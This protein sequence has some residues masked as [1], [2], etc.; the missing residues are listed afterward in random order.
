[1]FTSLQSEI[2]K[3]ITKELKIDLT[4]I[5]S[6]ILYEPGISYEIKATAALKIMEHFGGIWYLTKI[7]WL[8]P[9][10][11]RNIFYD[12]IAKNRYKWFGKKESCMLPTIEIKN[13]FL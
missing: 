2:G 1:M 8:I 4:K 9:E 10:Q 13:K 11:V 6:I 5:D 7:F 3:K 12:Y